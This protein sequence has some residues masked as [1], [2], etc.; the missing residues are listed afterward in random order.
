[1][2]KKNDDKDKWT[3]AAHQ[4][5]AVIHGQRAQTAG[6]S[7]QDNAMQAAVGVH[8]HRLVRLR[9]PPPLLL[10]VVCLHREMLRHPLLQPSLLFL[11]LY[12]APASTEKC[13]C[14]YWGSYDTVSTTI[15]QSTNQLTD[16]SNQ[17]TT[18]TA[19]L[20]KTLLHTR[21]QVLRRVVASACC[22]TAAHACS[23]V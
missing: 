2:K 6:T 7:T 12:K 4:K 3:Q 1:M 5:D 20:S 14:F 17:Y 10:T 18:G 13:T 22:G 21:Q 23:V 11:H 8:T 9:L 15:N 19:L 16:Q